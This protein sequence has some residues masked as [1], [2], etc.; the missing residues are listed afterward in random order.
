MANAAANTNE[1]RH[2]CTSGAPG[3]MS[4]RP[5]GTHGEWR[6]G[7]FGADGGTREEKG[8]PLGSPSCPSPS[9]RHG[10]RWRPRAL[11]GTR[12]SRSRAAVFVA[13][14]VGLIPEAR[15][16]KKA[17][18]G[19]SP[20]LASLARDFFRHL[21]HVMSGRVSRLL[22]LHFEVHRLT[23]II[24]PFAL[25]QSPAGGSALNFPPARRPVAPLLHDHERARGAQH[26]AHVLAV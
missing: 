14:A 16:V 1:R 8:A 13:A 23:C 22:S 9:V 2:G 24:Y 21:E 17:A 5:S 10:W 4:P 12:S 18:H 25:L 6:L 26:L 3:A 20:R 19:R 7:G 15:E 11:L